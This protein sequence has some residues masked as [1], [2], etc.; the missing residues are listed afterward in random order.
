M[1]ADIATKALLDQLLLRYE[2]SAFIA[3]DPIQV[4][5]LFTDT[6]DREV[7]G[8]L[9]A[10]IA[11]GQRKTIIQNAQ[12]L[13][14]YMDNS[15]HDFIINHQPADLRIFQRFVHR[16]FNAVDCCGFMAGLQ[17]I[18]QN[19][20]SLEEV[21]YRAIGK[22]ETVAPGIIFFREQLIHYLAPRTYKHIPDI[23][24]GA[25]AK[26]LNMFLRWM[27]RTGPVD[28]GCWSKISPA[29]LLCPLDIH[30]GRAARRLGLLSRKQ[31]DF[32][33]VT[34]LTAALRSFSPAD[35]VKYDIALFALS[36]EYKLN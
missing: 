3:S 27:V 33:A 15:P 11:W 31:N 1:A 17:K 4:P 35:P 36:I 22:S 8:L 34:E 29:Q 21:F 19:Y 18:Y 14:Q 7:A 12:K 25:A 9:T 6:K 5:H 10:T 16:T 20:Q 26:R 28:L 32:S 30:V 24:A 23:I 2:N 13:M